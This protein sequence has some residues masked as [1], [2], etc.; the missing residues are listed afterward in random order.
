MRIDH[1]Q[2][3]KQAAL[4]AQFRALDFGLNYVPAGDF[5]DSLLGVGGF[6]MVVKVR[7]LSNGENLAAKFTQAEATSMGALEESTMSWKLDQRH[8]VSAVDI[9]IYVSNNGVTCVRSIYPLFEETLQQ[10]M[11]SM[12]SNQQLLISSQISFFWSICTKLFCAVNYLWSL[13]IFHCGVCV[14]CGFL[15]VYL[16]LD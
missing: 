11:E 12:R 2:A 3:E 4:E 10:K 14:A 6:G 13:R 16:V 15:L 5:P 1:L 7:Q 9:G 8:V